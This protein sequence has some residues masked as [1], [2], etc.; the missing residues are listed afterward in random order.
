MEQ[1]LTEYLL[2]EGYGWKGPTVAYYQTRI[3]SFFAYLTDNHITDLQSVTPRIIKQFFAQLMQSGLSWSTRNG[4]YTALQ[5][6]YAWMDD[7]HHTANVFAQSKIKRPR[8][9]QR[10][11]R[12]VPTEAVIAMVSAAMAD[13][14]IIGVR[15]TAVMVLLFATGI[16]RA[17]LVALT[18]NDTDIPG[19]KIYVTGKNNKQRILPLNDDAVTVTIRWLDVRPQT[20]DTSL[21]VTLHPDNTGKNYHR[22]RPDNVNDIMLRYKQLAG[23]TVNVSPHKWRHAYATLL[24]RGRDPFGLQRLLGHENIATTA[25]YVDKTIDDLRAMVDNYIPK[26]TL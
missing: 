7:N 15:D 3:R 26:L 13:E 16:R 8:R 20:V 14:T 21:F 17:E 1:Y 18:I 6:W 22:M 4:T 9:E 25:I 19:R 23:I 2:D 10:V 24:S 5:Q 11:V 12:P